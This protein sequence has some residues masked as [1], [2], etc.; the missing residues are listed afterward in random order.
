MTVENAGGISPTLIGS[1]EAADLRDAAKAS[2]RWPW[3]RIARSLYQWEADFLPL[4]QYAAVVSLLVVGWSVCDWS[5]PQ[6]QGD[7]GTGQ[8]ID[9]GITLIF[10]VLFARIRY[11]WT[12][13]LDS[14]VT[15]LRRVLWAATLLNFASLVVVLTSS[16]EGAQAHDAGNIG[17]CFFRDLV[18]LACV[19]PATQRFT[20]LRFARFLDLLSCLND[21]GV[22]ERFIVR[23]RLFR[24]WPKSAIDPAAVCTIEPDEP[25]VHMSRRNLL[26]AIA[27]RGCFLR[28][29]IPGD[30]QLPSGWPEILQESESQPAMQERSPNT[31]RYAFLTLGLTMLA[32][33]MFGIGKFRTNGISTPASTVRTATILTAPTT[34]TDLTDDKTFR[35][36]EDAIDDNRFQYA[37][38]MLAAVQ[39]KNTSRFWGL[40]GNLQLSQNHFGTAA[41]DYRNAV[42]LDPNDSSLYLNLGI[43][44]YNDTKYDESI[45]SFR[46]CV[47][48]DPKDIEAWQFA[49]WAFVGEKQYQHA[50][51][52]VHKS[53]DLK[54][55]D[56]AWYDIRNT[57]A[58]CKKISMFG[59]C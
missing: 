46:N 45:D 44:L 52:V 55:D 33:L 9:T 51:D 17:W 48:L 1:Y 57:S 18:M 20:L 24:R 21:Y 27:G 5:N 39:T 7:F 8:W 37:A 50:I 34:P 41:D 11:L 13:Q 4:W 3:P 32:L 30:F 54:P 38:D 36:I 28:V 42:A 56:A 31:A 22:P 49:A 6:R 10:L 43:A 47:K 25:M 2:R 29:I 16:T 14:A 23:R 53:I 19:P 40:S 35:G 26:G 15:L 58:A 12:R 59:A